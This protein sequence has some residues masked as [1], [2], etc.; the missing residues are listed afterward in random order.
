MHVRV[1][2]SWCA[3]LVL[4]VA[5]S[6]PAT[7][8]ADA[9]AYDSA[10]NLDRPAS[11]NFSTP[12]D[13]ARPGV[14]FFYMAARAVAREQYGFAAD[15]YRT[16]ASWAYKP[17]QYNLGVMYLHGEGVPV[18]RPRAMAW[19]ALAAERGD[20]DYVAA[21][22]SLYAQLDAGEFAHANAIWREL[23][24]TYGDATA[25]RRAKGRWLQVRSA[26][27]AS[28]VGATGNL[29]IGGF[30]P[31]S[32]APVG[33]ASLTGGRQMTGALA[34]RQLW[35]SDNPYDPAFRLPQT[36]T[37]TVGPLIAL[38]EDNGADADERRDPDRD[39]H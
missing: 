22:E 6:V 39:Q 27:T 24:A 4:A 25:L 13:D 28:R 1:V 35:Q 2:P 9:P 17:A 11:W 33:A 18:D 37:A 36:G 7:R 15:M 14:Y 5:A 23:R 19:F 32:S 16:S 26:M 20:K 30:S 12:E 10:G 8:A 29:T 38:P 21:R 34:Y 3:C 31:S